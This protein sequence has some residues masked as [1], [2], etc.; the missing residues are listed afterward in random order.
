MAYCGKS[1]DVVKICDSVTL[2]LDT[3]LLAV[4]AEALALTFDVTNPFLVTGAEVVDPDTGDYPL[5][6]SA[7]YP[8]KVSW[9]YNSVLP[10]YEVVEGASIPDTYRQ[11]IGPVV[12]TDSE[13]ALGKANTKAFNS[14]MW[15]IIS[16]LKGAAEASKFHIYGVAN[17]LK[18]LPQA[19]APEFG[20][21][22]VGTFGSI[23]GGEEATPNGVNYLDGTYAETKALYLSRLEVVVIP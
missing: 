7:Y 2:N 18:F 13:S 16:P 3:D 11:L 10:S 8:V 15:K 21:R 14:N 19:T 23:T 6:A 22:V 9:M 5:P 12:I 20:N 17:G 1:A 4:R